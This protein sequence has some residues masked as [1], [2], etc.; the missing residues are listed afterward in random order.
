MIAMNRIVVFVV[1]TVMV[2][3]GYAQ[4]PF[5]MQHDIG[6]FNVGVA[7][8]RILQD[9]QSMIWFGTDI[10]LSRYD[11]TSCYEIPLDDTKI[12]YSVSTLFEDR[13]FRIWI[14][15]TSGKIF[16]MDQ[17][18]SI[19]EFDIDEG[20]PKVPISNICQDPGG[21]L[22][23]A[24]YGE[25]VY[26]YTGSR[27]YNFDE[28]DGLS[29]DD[30][31]DMVCTPIGEVWLG[32]DNG[33][34]ICSFDDDLKSIRT[35]GLNDGLPDQIVT[36][37]LADS[38]GNVW[39]GT[40]EFG[41]VF[42]DA[43]SNEI[44]SVFKPALLDEITAFSIFDKDELW[45]GTR[46]SGIW[47]YQSEQKYGERVTGLSQPKQGQVN[48]LIT[49]VEGNIWAVLENGGVVSGFR[50]FESVHLDVPEIQALYC[51]NQETLWLGTKG[52]L[53]KIEKNSE[54]PSKA[55][56][57][58][59]ELPLNITD[60]IEDDF[61]H[62]WIGTLDKGLYVYDLGTKKVKHF[63]SIIGEGGNTIMSMA[64]ANKEI[65]VATLEGV[66][67]YHRSSDILA[68]DAIDFVL[69]E[70]PWQSNLHFVFQVFVDSQNRTWFASDG[71]GVFRI[72]G[73][74]VDHFTGD[75]EVNIKTVYS[76]CE[77]DQ[78][79]FW[80]NTPDQG[81]IEFDGSH[82]IPYSLIE[83]LG[84]LE[85]A[86]INRLGTGDILI[87]HASGMDVLSPK[88]RH[89]MYYTEEIGVR[90]FEPG[91]NASSTSSL[92]HVYTSGRNVIF[93][94]HSPKQKLSIHPKTQITSVTVFDKQVNFATKFNFSH[95]QN[96][97]AFHYVGLWYTSPSAVKYLYKL[98][99]YDRQWKESKDNIASYSNLTSG[100]YT[101]LVKASENNLFHDEPT[102]TYSFTIAKPIWEEIWFVSLFALCTM[103][104][105]YWLVKSREKRSARQAI[106]RK[107]MIESQLNTLK[108]Q[109]NPHFL[110]NSFNTLI[111]IIDE[112]PMKPELAVK[113]VEKL[114]DFYRSILQ[115]REHEVITLS[116]EWGLVHNY[117]YLLRERYGDNLRLHFDTPPKDAYI[118]PLTLQMLVENAVK[119]NVISDQYPLDLY[120]T[121]EAE[122]YVTVKNT[123][124]PKSMSEPST[125]FGLSTISRRYQL[126]TDKK[127]IV[128]K[129]TDTFVVQVPIIKKPTK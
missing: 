123:L 57:I 94:C 121:V 69:L 119:H 68:N 37:L 98:D 21:N 115:Y 18:R 126:L 116:E 91:L 48:D 101:F 111:T 2:T 79:H 113:Y 75:E 86:S 118:M 51:D 11:G 80:W 31:Y 99:G 88:G 84:N 7:V 61:R 58:R 95:A 50:P 65:W 9:H 12:Q 38:K 43:L 108:A 59:P 71:N 92:G 74:K 97:I 39:I 30:I 22:W 10:G 76:I 82:Y 70:D 81:L 6:D 64:K 54:S 16:V 47:R 17:T 25:G 34:S 40:F 106:L 19:N 104:G 44:I 56:R 67:S 5:F 1:F 110:F 42:F 23:I 103:M 26:V 32:T 96:Y 8:K 89:V 20:N 66:V 46:T 87:T 28:A 3:S 36:T 24:T 100:N 4:E 109:I 63:G 107:D 14:G 102:A 114:S 83:G 73:D 33:I 45:I 15:T 77:D 85:V 62:L 55:I 129:N 53:F 60:I 125:Q 78:G 124:Q 128:K 127:V 122:E 72:D 29:G 117:V 93:K 13:D 52:G 90:N 35:L 112:N 120:I 49:D 27:L 41:V 105:F